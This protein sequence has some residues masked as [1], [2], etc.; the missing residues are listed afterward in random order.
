MATKITAV[1]L[2]LL[3]AIA[4]VLSIIELFERSPQAMSEVLL[5]ALTFGLGTL[6]W[7]QNA[8]AGRTA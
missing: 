7:D 1:G 5:S 2:M 3:G 6:V 8:R 4:L